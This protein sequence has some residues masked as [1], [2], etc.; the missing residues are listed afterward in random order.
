MEMGLALITIL[1]IIEWSSTCPLA[2]IDDQAKELIGLKT[3]LY[4]IKA[5]EKC[6][7]KVT[8]VQQL[9]VPWVLKKPLIS[10]SAVAQVGC[11]S[12]QTAQPIREVTNLTYECQS[13]NSGITMEPLSRCHA[14]STTFPRAFVGVV[15]RLSQG[16]LLRENLITCSLERN[17]ETL[18]LV[19]DGQRDGMLVYRNTSQWQK[20]CTGARTDRYD[21]GNDA[22]QIRCTGSVCTAY[23]V[24]EGPRRWAENSGDDYPYMQGGEKETIQLIAE[25]CTEIDRGEVNRVV[26]TGVRLFSSSYSEVIEGLGSH[27]YIDLRKMA[28]MTATPRGRVLT[29][30]NRKS[31]RTPTVEAN[32]VP[33][34]GDEI[35]IV[36]EVISGDIVL[37]SGERGTV[38]HKDYKDIHPVRFWLMVVFL[39]ALFYLLLIFMYSRVPIIGGHSAY[40]ERA[41]HSSTVALWYYKGSDW[42]EFEE[43]GL[44]TEMT[45]YEETRSR[46]R[47]MSS[48]SEVKQGMVAKVEKV[49]KVEVVSY[50]PPEIKTYKRV[51]LI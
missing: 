43:L 5:R 15:E 49:D 39:I 7:Y 51:Q 45:E 28:L 36:I 12:T 4:T 14:S 42:K 47:S 6:R 33:E 34:E 35:N 18:Y 13:P 27:T 48:V 24:F 31:E 20:L 29:K 41:T 25:A 10:Q 1:G 37:T 2:W 16:G 21:A 8:R 23:G 3:E 22:M 26:E 44:Y 17:L 11:L 19:R 30:T 32:G 9:N 50:S 38:H 46:P 40:I